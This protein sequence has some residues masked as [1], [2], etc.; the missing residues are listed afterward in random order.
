[1]ILYVDKLES[2]EKGGFTTDLSKIEH[3]ISTLGLNKAKLLASIETNPVLVSNLGK[4]V[5]IYKF[6][7]D[8]KSE[9]MAFINH[10]IDLDENFNIFADTLTPK[11][12]QAFHEIQEKIKM[13]DTD[14]L[15]HID[16]SDNSLLF[17]SFFEN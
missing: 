7:H 10:E 4:Y 1:M 17:Q 3:N 16:L 2:D 6:S 15:Q 13:R 11:L 8:F 12:V 14:Q 5:F 9:T